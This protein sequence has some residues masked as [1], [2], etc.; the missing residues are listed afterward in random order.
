MKFLSLMAM[1]T[2]CFSII[3]SGSA[4]NSTYW[5]NPNN[6]ME[7]NFQ[8]HI[9]DS[10]G[11]HA[12][13]SLVEVKNLA[14][15]PPAEV[16]WANDNQFRVRAYPSSYWDN[17]EFRAYEVTWERYVDIYEIYKMEHDNK[18]NYVTKGYIDFNPKGTAE[19]ELTIKRSGDGKHDDCDFSAITGFEKETSDWHLSILP[20][21]V[22]R[23]E[24]A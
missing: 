22:G 21:R 8:E 1:F 19:G 11:D 18:D 6:S 10:L 13:K 20:S 3:S 15:K 7:T 12:A 4:A 17:W 2:L 23:P 24:N 5:D 16:I 9:D 14:Y